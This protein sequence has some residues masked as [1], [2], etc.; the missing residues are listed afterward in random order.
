M[1]AGSLGK[2]QAARMQWLKHSSEP[3]ITIRSSEDSPAD[4]QELASE[5]SQHNCVLCVVNTRAQASELFQLLPEVGRFHLSAAMCAAHRSDKL[6]VI[7]QRLKEKKTCRL[8]STQLIE[9]GVDVDFPIAYRALGP[10]DSIIQTAG[11]CNREG[12]LLRVRF[13]YCIHTTFGR[14]AAW[15]LQIRCP[16]N[17]IVPRRIPGCAAAP[18]GNLSALFRSTLHKSLGPDSADQR[19]RI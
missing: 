14:N 10:L 4:W 11:R 17:R 12:C 2:F 19:L 5:I 15:C 13:C 6:A 3:P 1:T 7:R 18:A 8:I 16:R 9:A